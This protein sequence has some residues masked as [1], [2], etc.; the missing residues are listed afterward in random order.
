MD[1]VSAENTTSFPGSSL[2]FKVVQI[3]A[4]QRMLG[5]NKTRDKMAT[6]GGNNRGTCDSL[7]YNNRF[8]F[9]LF[10]FL[11]QR[12]TKMEASNPKNVPFELKCASSDSSK[13]VVT[14]NM[15]AEHASAVLK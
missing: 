9:M 12:I 14:W 15:P 4:G 3:N 11:W 8:K 2:G 13:K 5:T 1:F 6:R 7:V 10:D